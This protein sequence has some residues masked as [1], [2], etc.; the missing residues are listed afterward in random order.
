M[1]LRRL[2]SLLLSVL[3]IASIASVAIVNTAAADTTTAETGAR[4]GNYYN[5]DYLEDKAYNGTDLGCTYTPSK[6]TWKVWSPNA[7]KIQ[8]KLF[9]TGSDLE[10]ISLSPTPKLFICAP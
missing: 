10:V 5:V 9:K 4:L 8:L 6:T 3:M 2:L 1:K 7:T